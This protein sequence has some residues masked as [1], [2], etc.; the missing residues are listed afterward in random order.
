MSRRCLDT[1]ERFF[2]S[3]IMPELAELISRHSEPRPSRSATMA[4]IDSEVLLGSTS[5]AP[6]I[7]A[8]VHRT[9]VRYW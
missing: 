6:C 5:L 4:Y 2:C 9:E 7:C 8:R 3:L 1:E